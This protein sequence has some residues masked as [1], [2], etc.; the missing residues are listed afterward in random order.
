M[1]GRF[2]TIVNYKIAIGKQRVVIAHTAVAAT[3]VDTVP[4][5]GAAIKVILCCVGGIVGGS[6]VVRHLKQGFV[7]RR[8]RCRSERNGRIARWKESGR[9]PI[10]KRLDVSVRCS[11]ATVS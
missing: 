6:R 7:S 1:S 3:T 11:S 5:T 10:W 2:V 4:G 9:S 8:G